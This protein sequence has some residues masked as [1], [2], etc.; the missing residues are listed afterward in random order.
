MPNA[1]TAALVIKRTLPYPA[2]ALFRAFSDPALMTRWFFTVPDWS[3]AVENEFR[4]GGAYK[5]KMQDLEGG[6]YPH[7]GTYKEI[8]PDRKIT[9]TWNSHLVTDT[10]VTVT[11]APTG[12][13][14]EIT[15]VHEFLPNEEMRGAHDWGWKG[16]LD[17]L[18]VAMGS[19]LAG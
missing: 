5:V 1:E 13:G 14:T 18:A 19:G 16:C 7:H 10:L 4:V 8:V 15:L 9:F 11:F 3:V 12:G 2:D 17:N 6:T